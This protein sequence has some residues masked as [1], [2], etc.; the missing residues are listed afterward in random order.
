MCEKTTELR[1]EEK[2][3]ISDNDDRGPN[4]Y[5]KSLVD[6]NVMQQLDCG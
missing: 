6:H 2:F 5:I 4:K 3:Q 1:A